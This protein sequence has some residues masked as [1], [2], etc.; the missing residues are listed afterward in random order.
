MVPSRARCFTTLIVPACVA[1]AASAQLVLA[2][3]V[4]RWVEAAKQEVPLLD[5]ASP[6]AAVDAHEAGLLLD[7]REPA[8]RVTSGR[9]PGAINMPRGIVELA[10]WAKVGYPES[11]H[12]GQK[13]TVY[14]GT[15]WAQC[16][17]RQVPEGPRFHPCAARQ[18]P[19]RGL[20]SGRLSDGL[21]AP[22]TPAMAR[23]V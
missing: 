7:V 15:T 5:L 9:W 6:K 12:F 8:E 18:H 19:G 11:T 21:V 4:T 22:A 13:I 2:P 14:C 16:A 1:P 20:A 23:R 17:G 10:I 3:P